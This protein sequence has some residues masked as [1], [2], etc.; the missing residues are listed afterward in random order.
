MFHSDHGLR[1]PAASD[2]SVPPG[3]VGEGE[4]LIDDLLGRSAPDGCRLVF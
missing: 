1:I 3:G 4:G 2:L